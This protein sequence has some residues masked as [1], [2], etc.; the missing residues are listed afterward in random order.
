MKENQECANGDYCSNNGHY[1]NVGTYNALNTK[2]FKVKML[3]FVETTI[4]KL[5]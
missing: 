1:K 3:P 2:P 4:Y 5:S